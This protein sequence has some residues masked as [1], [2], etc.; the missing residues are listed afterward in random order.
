[1]ALHKIKDFDPDYRQHFDDRDVLGYDLYSGS[2]KIGS[3]SDLLVDDDGRFRYF[4]V[5]L[6]VWIFGKKVLLPIGQA[7]ISYTD[8][9]I[10]AEGLTREQAE[11][12]PEYDESRMVDYDQE[13]RVRNIYRPNAVASGIA[14]ASLDTATPVEG[15]PLDVPQAASAP[16][17][18]SSTTPS[19]LDY[20][21][22]S[23]S[24]DREPALYN[25]PA[26]DQTLRLYEERIIANKQRLKTGEVTVGKHVETETASVTVP[27]EKERVVIERNPVMGSSAVPVGTEVFQSGE[28]ARVEVYEEVPDIHKEAFVREE[29]K[30]HKE[31]QQERVTAQET[32]RR[33]ELDVD[34]DGNPVVQNPD[35]TRRI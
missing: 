3:I 11:H 25:L 20:D 17:S 27:V 23:Y 8:R 29:V 19:T 7:R 32:I 18:T 2:E 13:E 15:A 28:V 4:V 12:L 1:M 6:G 22:N 35:Q 16:V 9:R 30:V 24:Y 26:D 10:Y 31:V 21:R 34:T 14:S 33:E 5:N